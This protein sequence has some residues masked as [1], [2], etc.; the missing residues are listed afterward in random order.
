M[1]GGPRATRFAYPVSAT[2]LRLWICFG[3]SGTERA[4]GHRA[5][6]RRFCY[7]HGKSFTSKIKYDQF[8]AA[9]KPAE[10]GGEATG[11]GVK[12]GF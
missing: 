12:L 2:A 4:A 8:D 5:A 9:G 7:W 1:S 10:G 3:R 6:R 11:K